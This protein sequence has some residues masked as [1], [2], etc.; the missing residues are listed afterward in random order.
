MRRMFSL[1]ILAVSI[2]WAAVAH[3]SLVSYYTFNDPADPGYD[4][5]VVRDVAGGHDAAVHGGVWSADAGGYTGSPGDYAM[6]FSSGYALVDGG[7]FAG[8]AVM[9][10]AITFSFWQKA[11][12]PPGSPT[13][14]SSFWAESPGATGTNR[15]A[16]A[17]VPHS[18]K[19]IY[20]DTAGCCG[21]D[22]RLRVGASGIIDDNDWHHV[23][24]VKDG[25][26]KEIWV[27]GT[28]LAQHD[29]A[30]RDLIPFSRLFIGSNNSG[31]SN[32]HGFIDDFA[33]FDHPLGPADIQALANRTITPD[34]V[35]ATVP[36]TLHAQSDGG[37]TVYLS[38]TDKLPGDP[39]DGI[40]DPL[41]QTTSGSD[42][43]TEISV[44]V[45][46]TSSNTPYF[47]HIQASDS[48][49]PRSLTAA[50]TAPPGY[51]F[52]QTGDRNLL[53]EDGTDHSD[54]WTVST[55]TWGSPSYWPMPAEKVGD[56]GA[57]YPAGTEQVWYP[58]STFPTPTVYF[59]T[60]MSITGSPAPPEVS[61]V[62]D[63]QDPEPGLSAR[64]VRV[65]DNLDNLNEADV[66]LNLYPGHANHS[67]SQVLTVDYAHVDV[68]GNFSNNANHSG[69]WPGAQDNAAAEDYAT[70]LAG[71]VYAQAG[72]VRAIAGKGDDH[73]YVRIGDTEIIRTNAW[74]HVEVGIVQFPETGYYPIE[75]V[76]HNRGGDGGFEVSVSDPISADP[77]GNWVP[78]VY[79][80]TNY[81]ILGSDPTFPV[82]Q[83]PEAVE[84][85]SLIPNGLLGYYY[86]LD[87]HGNE[88][89][90]TDYD[91]LTTW[92][93]QQTPSYASP[94]VDHP[95]DFPVG[96]GNDHTGGNP[97]ADIGVNVGNDSFLAWWTGKIN[98]PTDGTYTFYTASDDGSVLY[99]DGQLVV[100]NNYWQSMT[101]RSGTIDLTAGLHNIDIAW[102]EGGGDA[103]MT[104]SWAPP[105][106]SKE[107][108][109]PEVFSATLTDVGANNVGEPLLEGAV[110]T[111]K[112]DGLR[113]QQAFPGYGLSNVDQSVEFF[114]HSTIYNGDA[115]KFNTGV[116]E[117]RTLLDMTDPQNSG[118]GN[119]SYNNPFPI[120][121]PADDNNFATRINGLIYIP[122]PGTYAFTV[123]TDDGFQL[124]I[125]DKV[126]GRYA[127]NR[128]ISSGS[129]NYLYG[130]FP[131]AGLYPFEF[132]SYE[133]GGGSAI[134]IAYGGSTN[135]LLSTRNPASN[136]FTPDWGGRAFSVEPVA[137][138]HLN[139]ATLKVAAKSFG[140][141]PA[142]GVAVPPE[143]WHLL[144]ITQKGSG[145]KQ[146]GLKAE[147]YDFS[148]SYG[149]DDAHK[150]GERTVLTSGR[151][152][153]GNNYA[154]GPWGNLENNFGV[155]FTGYLFAPVTGTYR[156]HMQSDDRSWIFLDVD[157]DG[158][159]EAAPGNDS[160][161]VWWDVDL[162]QG[163]HAIELRS[164]EF[165]GGEWTRLSWLLPGAESASG[166]QDIPAEYFSQNLY[167]GTF[168]AF[169]LASGTGQIGDLLSFNDIDYPFD[170]GSTHRL[171]LVTEIAGL[172]A[173]AEAQIT[174]VP[175]PTTSLLLGA[176]LLA[177]LR[178]RRRK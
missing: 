174:F 85:G 30:T 21:G 82:Y 72:E 53:T 172:M 35:A 137:E 58:Q 12:Y 133:G 117:N 24:F 38:P 44:P 55:S 62:T 105:G 147:Y 146:A 126:L 168:T 158:V 124:R 167:D 57:N 36:V 134:E 22:T 119:W 28:R 41:Y 42:I 13:A 86:N 4:P 23:A 11:T 142:L 163:L 48:T 46:R 132:Y 151:F 8:N 120:N 14:S 51:A 34:Q 87:V 6:D 94:L 40:P 66:A 90:F 148:S 129:A 139:Y 121:T 56:A 47:L 98:V 45:G 104:A 18:D 71:Y 175:E 171:M 77:N 177:L 69:Y 74:N 49:E 91:A 5:S 39:G 79:N 2:A 73:I 112:A 141:V 10:D 17:H 84:P 26:H 155:R 67:V 136:G 76:S 131:K 52:E 173:L 100:S 99:I 78:P 50:L 143:R 156:F 70:K 54:G 60:P 109:P 33:V 19:R 145:P 108:I 1:F 83:R 88:S 96:G 125:G 29:S 118:G 127:G 110:D 81:H 169:I 130:Y 161:H 102:Y 7:N 15:G 152:N 123:G 138:M 32:F 178:R 97:L 16:Q 153:F 9:N 93:N 25:A 20:W 149:W 128:G 75:I 89:V 31:A 164:R 160:G 107:L 3:A 166:W 122:Q 135:L 157:G 106:G 103:G 170:F 150:V 159:L 92:L 37:F 61:G 63:L 165:G 176:G 144:E 154:Y 162:A 68:Q 27:D 43:T 111:A 95:I 115:T 116:V 113:V 80:T 114:A 64:V 65:N 101:E 59:T 140:N